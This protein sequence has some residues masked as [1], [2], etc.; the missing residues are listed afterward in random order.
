MPRAQADFKSWYFDH[1]AD[2]N[3]AHVKPVWDAAA[4]E[5]SRMDQA[6]EYALLAPVLAQLEAG[7]LQGAKAMVHQRIKELTA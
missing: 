5:Q 6:Q 4:R 2:F 3:A 7:D 1:G